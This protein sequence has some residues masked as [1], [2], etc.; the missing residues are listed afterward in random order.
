M[1]AQILIA[2]DDKSQRHTLCRLI[3]RK[4]NY[5]TI[6]AE[7]GHACIELLNQDQKNKIKLVILDLYMPV[8]DGMEALEAISQQHPDLP[9]IILT[10]H[11][12]VDNAVQAMKF[13]AADFLTKPVQADRMIVSIQNALK[14]S[15]LAKE[16]ARLNKKDQG[17]FSF[18]DLI[19]G[20]AGLVSIVQRGRK[21]ASSNIP[22]LLTGET[23]VGKEVFAHAIHGES[24]RSGKSFIAVNCGALPEQLVES[25]LFGHEKGAFTGAVAKTAGKFREANGGS[26]FLDEV[27][28][29]PPDTQVKLLRVLQQKEVEPVGSAKT[30]PVDVRVISAT[31]R[32]LSEEVKK[33]RFRE[34]LYYRLNVL[35]IEIPPLRDRKGD[36]L[37]LAQH[38]IERFSVA[39]N[40]QSQSLTKEAEEFLGNYSWAGNV[41]ELENAVHRAVVLSESEH[42]AIENFTDTIEFK[43]ADKN[44]AH[45]FSIPMFHEDGRLKTLDELEKNALQIA[46]NYY[47]HNVTKTA[48][49]LGI[50]KSTFYRK[51]RPD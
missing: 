8:M 28:E 43:S 35:Q 46:L 42:L 4:M 22:V 24:Q 38:F 15:S 23:G 41:R 2:D 11:S 3:E 12:K 45:P 39:E 49:A 19:G 7:N 26:I 18:N 36:I 37:S 16:V 10:G 32:D 51:A 5:E 9:V 25:I 48:E 17:S 50:A 20:D 27:G 30:I 13:G 1:G 33:G 31:N 14:M 29:L 34:D 47:N 6:E 40:K 44:L 21:A